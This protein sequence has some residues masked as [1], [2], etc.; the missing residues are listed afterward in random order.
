[1]SGTVGKRGGAGSAQASR[2]TSIRRILIFLA[3]AFGLAWSVQIAA[4]IALGSFE[5]GELGT[6]AITGFVTASMFAPLL[7]ALATNRIMGEGAG[8]DLCVRPRLRRNAGLYAAAWFAPAVLSAMGAALFFA[9]NPHFF[10]ISMPYMAS[11]AESSGAAP[12]PM[13]DDPAAMAAATIVSAVLLAPIVNAVPAFGE[14]AG[15]RGMLFPS[16]CEVLP[17]RGAAVVSGVV[18]GLW[19]IPI[20]LMGHNFGMG[21]PG[22]PLSNILVM[23]LACTSLGVVL[24]ALRLRSGSVW[25]CALAHGAINAIANVWLLFCALGPD[26]WG[27]SPLL[28]PSPLA[29]VSG[30]P[31]LVLAALLLLAGSVW[32]T[33]AGPDGAAAVK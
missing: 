19:H 2:D 3:L 24:A 30:I 22:F 7:A 15:W 21:T 4:G 20:I 29:L 1:M 17:V 5:K 27:P 6:P 32:E 31:M 11:L 12:S 33:G 18:W 8:V 10:D 13:P 14:E 28:G 16:L 26:S 25:P 9:T 23:T